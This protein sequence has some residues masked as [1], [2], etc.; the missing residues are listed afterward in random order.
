MA[1]DHDW[2]NPEKLGEHDS[3]KDVVQYTCG[4]CMATRTVK[5]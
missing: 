2:Q 4:K 1:C 5:E 3:G